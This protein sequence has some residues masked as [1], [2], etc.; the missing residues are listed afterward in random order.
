MEMMDTDDVT[1][2]SCC[3]PE[4]RSLMQPIV[5]V[6]IIISGT[7][8]HKTVVNTK[9]GAGIF[10]KGLDDL[11]NWVQ[12]TSTKHDEPIAGSVQ[13]MIRNWNDGSSQTFYF[14]P[15]SKEDT[16]FRKSKRCAYILNLP[17]FNQTPSSHLSNTLS[18][19]PFVKHSMSLI[20]DI[21]LKELPARIINHIEASN[22]DFIQSH[23]H[24]SSLFGHKA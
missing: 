13:E 17:K 20:F 22:V 21:L 15:D 2:A 14:R 4:I 12:K 9:N 6:I 16:L 11:P 19:C 23:V 5:L 18:T 8:V 24:N 3:T 10:V 1:F 7:H